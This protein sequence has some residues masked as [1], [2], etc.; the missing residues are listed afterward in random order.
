M[1][2]II[3]KNVINPSFINLLQEKISLNQFKQTSN[4]KEE[5]YFNRIDFY[6]PPFIKNAHQLIF[7][8]IAD[9]VFPEKVKGSYCIL[10]RY[11]KG[12]G[13]C[14]L[15][16]DRKQCKY[17]IGLCVNQVEVWD[18]WINHNSVDFIEEN[19]FTFNADIEEQI[20]A[21]SKSYKLEIGDA[22]C[23]SGTDHPHWRSQIQSNNFC[24]MVLFHFV[25]LEFAGE[26]N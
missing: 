14:P 11:K 13:V 5:S 3:L 9:D 22:I 12:K 26:I 15:H 6:E 4:S 7:N 24:D 19:K 17:T 20:K 21:E 23:Y 8:K 1:T 10:V 16:I 25:P 2:P 18:F